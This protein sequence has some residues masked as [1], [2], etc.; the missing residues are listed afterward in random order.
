M[1]AHDQ[2]TVE[3]LT[4]KVSGL[5]FHARVELLKDFSKD[6]YSGSPKVITEYEKWVCDAH[7]MRELRNRFFHGRWGVS[8]KN[9]VANVIGL[10]TSPNQEG[11]TFTIEELTT[12]CETIKSL[13]TRLASL[14]KEHPV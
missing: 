7:S 12:H 5:N 14:R 3:K 4:K 8:A 9:S 1:W 13:G 2:A 6:R 10:P 11:K